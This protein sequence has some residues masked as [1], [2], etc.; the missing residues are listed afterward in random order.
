[1]ELSNDM[2]CW[3]AYGWLWV[4]FA[5]VGVLSQWL[6][7]EF[8]DLI[9]TIIV[10][11]PVLSP[12]LSASVNPQL[13]LALKVVG[14]VLFSWRVVKVVV[15]HGSPIPWGLGVVLSAR[16]NRGRGRPVHITSIKNKD[17]IWFGAILRPHPRSDKLVRTRLEF[18]F[19]ALPFRNAL[20]VRESRLQWVRRVRR[21][22]LVAEFTRGT[23]PYLDQLQSRPR[24]PT[25]TR[26]ATTT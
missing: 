8:V 14:G 21:D 17:R 11:F 2:K 12:A 26:R 16:E 6:Y 25:D 7:W 10:G 4:W 24:S 18:L 23:K 1:M 5:L 19:L 20:K 15:L 3:V 13:A 22:N 9:A